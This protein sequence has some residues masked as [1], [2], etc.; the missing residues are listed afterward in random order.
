MRIALATDTFT[1]QVNGVTTVLQRIV[2]ITT[3]AGH[4]TAVIAPRYPTGE[5]GG[6]QRQLRLPSV[7]F[8]PYPAIRMT[9]PRPGKVAAFLDAFAPEAIHVATEGPV[10]LMGR[11]YAISRAIPLVTSFHTQFPQYARHYGMAVLE[12]WVWRWLAWFHRPARWTHTPGELIRDELVAH[13]IPQARVWGNGA[14]ITQFRPDRRDRTWRRGFGI[15]EDTVLILHVGRLA[16]EKNVET[17]IDAWRIAREALGRRAVF[18]IAGEGPKSREV[19]RALPWARRLGF[20]GRDALATLYASADLC[21]LPSATET[22]GLVA[23]EAMASGLTVIAA[24]AGGFRETIRTDVDGVL[25]PPTDAL[26]FAAR[27]VEL[28]L[29]TRRRRKLAE[30]ARLA[31]E[32]RDIRIENEVLLQHYA[33][34][35]DTPDPVASSCAA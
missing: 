17:L 4:Q 25:V 35:I 13:G 29:D 34:L 32:A 7:R 19:D 21:V 10:G 30:H 9:L 11:R 6:D 33:E 3:A 23:I 20:L 28:A 27:I 18:L 15:E 5:V 8:P 26:G 2:R 24:D 16:P 1:P 22:C 14:D 31:A 12:P